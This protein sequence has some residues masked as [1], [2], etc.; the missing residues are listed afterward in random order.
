[1]FPHVVKRGDRFVIRRCGIF[2]WDYWHRGWSDWTILPGL[3][4][5]YPSREAAKEAWDM[6]KIA[7]AIKRA[8][9]REKFAGWL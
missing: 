8:Q 1:M 6:A 7:A 2:G 3:A 5:T 4:T 9:G